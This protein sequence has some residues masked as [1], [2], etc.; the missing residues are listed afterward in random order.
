MNSSTFLWSLKKKQIQFQSLKEIQV[1]H[2][3]VTPVVACGALQNS[4]DQ[5]A[6]SALSHS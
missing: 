5:V 2:E 3:T 6:V 1:S 4:Q